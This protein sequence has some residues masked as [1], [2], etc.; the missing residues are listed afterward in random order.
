MMFS[1]GYIASTRRV[2]SMSQ[3][4]LFDFHNHDGIFEI[5]PKVRQSDPITAK[6]AAEEIGEVVNERCRQ[7]LEGLV[8]LGSATANE[9]AALVAKDNP[10]LHDS[11]RR[12][13]RDLLV[14]GKIRN[15]RRRACS[16]TGKTVAYF[17]PLEGRK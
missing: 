2:A 14:A 16:V 7:F 13:Y 9:V 12:R 4:E 1:Q 17:E 11:I 15:A 3:G 5:A 10:G 8:T 6:E